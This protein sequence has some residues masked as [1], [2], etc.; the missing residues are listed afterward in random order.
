MKTKDKT[1]AKRPGENTND[2]DEDVN[3]KK[4]RDV[5]HEECLLLL[6]SLL[7]RLGDCKR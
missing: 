3:A 7:G 6:G 1:D 2:G 4:E 5:R